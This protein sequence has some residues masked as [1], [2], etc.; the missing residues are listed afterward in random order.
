MCVSFIN[1]SPN[2]EGKQL[3]II[4]LILGI[5]IVNLSAQV[6]GKTASAEMPSVHV[7]NTAEMP[8]GTENT[9]HAA[10]IDLKPGNR[11]P[12]PVV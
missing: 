3:Y 10:H 11:M 4:S 2:Y 9:A 12:F 1:D 6:S 5:F 7:E 8:S